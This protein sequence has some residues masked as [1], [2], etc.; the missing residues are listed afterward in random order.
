MKGW[1]TNKM[2]NA[3]KLFY[4]LGYIKRF[5]TSGFKNVPNTIIYKGEELIIEFDAIYKGVEFK[6]VNNIDIGITM[7]E[8]KAINMK[9]EE[10]N[11]LGD[12]N[13]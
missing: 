3:D 7:Q 11:W 2:S 12:T 5:K 8:L 9:C 1:V 13:E 4:E 10:L 6:Q